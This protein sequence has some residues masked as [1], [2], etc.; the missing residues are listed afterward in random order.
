MVGDILKRILENYE[1]VAGAGGTASAG[2]ANAG[3]AG[4]VA[5][6]D[7]AGGGAPICVCVHGERGSGKTALLEKVKNTLLMSGA[8]VFFAVEKEVS[9]RATAVAGANMATTTTGA[10]TTK[11]TATSTASA[12]FS[13]QNDTQKSDGAIRELLRQLVRMYGQNHDSDF[14][15]FIMSYAK[16]T[17]TADYCGDYSKNYSKD[18]SEDCGKNHSEDYNKNYGKNKTLPYDKAS[19]INFVYNCIKA[20]PTV[21]VIDDLDKADTFTVRLIDNLFSLNA[22]QFLVISHTDRLE[23]EV[24]SNMLYRNAKRINYVQLTGSAAA[25]PI[26]N[27]NT[28]IANPNTLDE[29][30]L[31]LSKPGMEQQLIRHHIKNAEQLSMQMAYENAAKTL[32]SALPVC[33]ALIDGFTKSAESTKITSS[34]SRDVMFTQIELLTKLGDAQA[35]D[36]Q[37]RAAADSYSHAFQ[38]TMNDGI[39]D[40]SPAAKAPDLSEKRASL[41]IKLAECY[42]NLYLPDKAREYVMLAEAFFCMPERR[43]QFYELYVK[44]I[45]R[46]LY[47]LAELNERV[48]FREKLKQAY[49]TCLLDDKDFTASLYCEEGYLCIMSGE[50]EKAHGLLTDARSLADE[51]GSGKLWDESTNCLA[52]CCEHMGKPEISELLWGELLKRS[53]DAVRR[54]KAMVNLS[55]MCFEKDADVNKAILDI[56]AGIDLCILAGE[57][58]IAAEIRENLRDTPLAGL[59]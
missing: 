38:V 42:N 3:V 46:Y 55:V 56:Q 44:Y 17:L 52:I 14:V 50:F 13:A 35:M 7:S 23:N 26:A 59:V 21:F 11:T 41:S 2:G 58:R 34:S 24:L 15:K 32:A 12:A 39:F 57:D 45:P 25:M 43:A 48:I 20:E 33:N 54:A 5:G 36:S 40:D 19:I 16:G 30:A 8:N 51:L 4:L 29:T 47:L 53:H 22:L 1:T 49:I 6:A 28:P 27:P 37:F 31:V 9:A 18:Y 10:N